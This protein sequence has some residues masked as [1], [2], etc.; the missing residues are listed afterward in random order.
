MDDGALEGMDEIVSEFLVESEENLDELDQQLV[1]LEADPSSRQ[2]LAGIFRTIHTIKGTSGFLAFSDLERL[3]HVGETLLARLRDG[4]AVATPQTVTVLLHMVDAVRGLL[5][6]I[7]ATGSDAGADL[8]GVL[9]AST[10]GEEGPRVVFVH[11]LF[12][13]GRNWATVARS[14]AGGPRR[15][16]V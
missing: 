6:R 15:V 8:T 1:A 13:Q 3:A 14:L 11:G 12:G 7:E 2:L 5:G 4:R 10:V 9:A 16:T